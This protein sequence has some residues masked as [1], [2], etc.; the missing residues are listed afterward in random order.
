MVK[1]Y[2]L[3]IERL[4]R[5]V[6]PLREYGCDDIELNPYMAIIQDLNGRVS[7]ILLQRFITYYNA[8]DGQSLTY[9]VSMKYDINQLI[10]DLNNIINLQLKE[11]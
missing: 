8:I 11:S 7:R 4:L 1:Q 9:L 6:N 10:Y 3:E 5:L 2:A